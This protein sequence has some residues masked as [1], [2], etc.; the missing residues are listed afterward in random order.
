MQPATV[1]ERVSL[2]ALALDPMPP[3]AEYA[4]EFANRMDPRRFDKRRL[5]SG[6]RVGVDLPGPGE[7]A[8]RPKRHA[9]LV[10]SFARQR[11]LVQGASDSDLAD[12]GT[13]RH[14]VRARQP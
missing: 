12:R 5:C 6:E 2:E 9:S 11:H 14:R 13:A 8:H 7:E 4:F 10:Q 3:V 1:T